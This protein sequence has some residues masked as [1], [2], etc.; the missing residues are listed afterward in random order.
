M[1]DYS[2]TGLSSPVRIETKAGWPVALTV[3]PL[4]RSFKAGE[5]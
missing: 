4:H 1:L 2:C 5:D 3:G